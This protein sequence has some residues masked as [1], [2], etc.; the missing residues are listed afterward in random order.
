M[1]VLV[2]PAEGAPNFVLRKFTLEP[3]G[4]IPLHR[5]PSVEH[6]QYVLAGRI[7]ITLGGEVRLVQ[8][9][10]AVFIPAG[11]PHRY[12]NAGPEVAEFLCVVPRTAA[13]E[14]EWLE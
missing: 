5:H 4:L 9:G 6:E 10:D 3:Q 12:E 2:G 11:V 13:Y 8:A 7:R 1:Q 14:T